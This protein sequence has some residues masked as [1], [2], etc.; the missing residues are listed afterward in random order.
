M[1]L[2]TIQCTASGAQQCKWSAI[3]IWD[4]WRVNGCESN[5]PSRWRQRRPPACKTSEAR[6]EISNRSLE[7]QTVHN[8]SF[9]NSRK[10]IRKKEAKGRFQRKKSIKKCGDSPTHLLLSTFLTTWGRPKPSSG[11][12]KNVLN[13][14]RKLEDILICMKRTAGDNKGLGGVCS[15]SVSECASDTSQPP[16]TELWL[17]SAG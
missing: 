7:A 14:V 9:R 11:G 3:P 15:R 16:M 17:F 12:G 4:R 2:P 6:L 10:Q 5:P 1:Q 13:H 8:H